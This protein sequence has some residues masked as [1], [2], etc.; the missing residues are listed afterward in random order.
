[1]RLHFIDALKGFGII[2]VV[3]A[4]H[5]IPVN[6]ETY[7]YSFHMP[8]FFFISGFLF[9]FGKYAESTSNFVKKRF[10]S[11]IVPY[12]SFA[13]FAYLFYILLGKAFPYFFES[14]K[15]N[16]FIYGVLYAPGDI[17]IIDIINPP[18]WFLPCLF[19]T[20]LLFY[21]LTKLSSGESRKLVPL[22]IAAGVIGYLYPV[23]VP[24]RLPWAAD[25]A[26]S[27]VVFYGA[28][29]LF[30]KFIESKVEVKSRLGLEADS[31]L[32]NTSSQVNRFFTGVLIL[33][34]LMYIGYLMEFPR[35]D[36]I[37]LDVME[38]GN[39]FSFYFLAFLGILTFYYLFEKIG[40]S[41][42]LE[43]YGRNSLIVLAFHY[44]MMYIYMIFIYLLFGI[45]LNS[46][47]SNAVLALGLTVLNLVL[48]VPVI[49]IINN[50]FPFILG[51]GS[52]KR[53]P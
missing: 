19:V 12:F 5:S 6:L 34:S 8:L 40:S 35:T 24:F 15:L 38:Y 1:M 7:I 31:N 3:F 41:R 9:D 13:L 25:V 32:G 14:I 33:P 2:L 50:Y 28:G 22:I 39:F 46:D 26:L 27:A 21:G 44:P 11:L 49:H 30:K 29:N 10:S 45:N 51:K 16:D 53:V 23:Y 20:G 43:Y 52:S 17:E 36:G 37:A 18:L 47:Y 4:H 48:M 42:I